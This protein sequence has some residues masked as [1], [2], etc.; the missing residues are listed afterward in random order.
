[1]T[2][3]HFQH[4]RQGM[5]YIPDAIDEA[6]N[7]RIEGTGMVAPSH[8]AN[9]MKDEQ[10]NFEGQDPTSYE[11][12]NLTEEELIEADADYVPSDISPVDLAEITSEIYESSKSPS[13]ELASEILRAPMSD[14]AADTTVTY[15]AHKFYQGEVTTD[16]A[17][18]EALNSGIPPEA[19]AQSY[20]KLQSYLQ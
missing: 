1:M 18:Q 3:I 5:T 16:E 12:V 15:L 8:M 9:M 7:E 11:D 10:L 14:S 6:T 13:Q 2:N 4:D 17:Y 20:R 19:L